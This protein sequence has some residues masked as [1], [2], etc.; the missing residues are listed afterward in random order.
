MPAQGQ[1]NEVSEVRHKTSLAARSS[2]LIFADF[3][4]VFFNSA[5]EKYNVAANLSCF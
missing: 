3:N 5:F 2:K 1:K 4:R